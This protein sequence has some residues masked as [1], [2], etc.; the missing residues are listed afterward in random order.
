MICLFDKSIKDDGII[1]L[2]MLSILKVLRNYC[3]REF[4][5]CLCINCIL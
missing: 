5:F 1:E 2:F 3:L 4:I